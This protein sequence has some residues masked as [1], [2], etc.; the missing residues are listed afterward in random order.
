MEKWTGPRGEVGIPGGERVTLVIWV[1]SGPYREDNPLAHAKPRK[2][3]H[4][5]LH[6]REEMGAP[7]GV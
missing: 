7:Y 3:S 2:R 5:P 1:S 4:S 6:T